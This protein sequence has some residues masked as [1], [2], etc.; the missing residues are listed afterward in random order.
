[1]SNQKNP[2][3]LI[4]E[5]SPYL[6]QHAY[7]PVAWYPWGNEAFEKAKK[8]EKPIFLSIGYST[9]HWCHVMENESFEDEEVANL[10]N[11]GFISIKVDKEERPDIDTVYMNVCQAYNGHGG[12][13]LTI[14]MTPE[15][16]PFFAGTYLPKLSRSNL[17]GLMDLLTTVKKQWKEERLPL[18]AAGEKITALL[19]SKQTYQ[20]PDYMI[21]TDIL[22]EGYQ[23][24][25][26]T[27]DPN[28]GGFGQSPKFP[29]PHNLLFL[30]RYGYFE[31]NEDATKMVY[32]T[33]LQMYLGGIYDHIGGGFSRYSTDEKWL[34]PHFEKMLYDNA[35]L[36]FT[37]LEAYEISKI[38]L[39]KTV[40]IRTLDYITREMLDES[41]GFYCAQDADS[42]GVEGKFYVFQKD[43][44][45]SVLGI[46]DGTYFCDY[47]GVTD[48]GN[49]EGSNILNLLK[50]YDYDKENARIPLLSTK[51]YEYRKTRT[52]LHKDDKILTSWN[53]LMIVA[54][55]KAY[56]VL[57]DE[58]YLTTASNS[59]DFILNNMVGEDHTLYTSYRKTRGSH[60][61]T[62]DDYS[63]FIWA[64]IEA[65]EVT[66]DVKY[67][68]LALTFNKKMTTEFFDDKEG[69]FYL[70]GFNSE[71]LILHPKEI[72][73]GAIPSGNSVATYCLGKLNRLTSDLSIQKTYEKQLGFLV[74][75]ISDYPSGYSFSLLSIINELY[76][77]K[78][79]ICVPA[80]TEEANNIKN[81]LHS[82]YLPNV[83]IIF[84]ERE[85]EAEL[86]KLIPNLENYHGTAGKT[87]FYLCENR[88][89]SA[90]FYSLEKLAE[91]LI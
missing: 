65:Y 68:E 73:D 52:T 44:I 64:L 14:L 78:E 69:G 70:Y 51:L 13:P 61:G 23:I 83:I 75:S 58:I 67:L 91:H 19:K 82:L 18:I 2:N 86:V 38:D 26:Q 34:V 89:C 79:L 50:N 3:K 33:L 48:T 41:G 28:Y 10:L 62:I 57:K 40:A 22:D 55:L 5:K 21:T 16:K 56:K 63:F 30:L 71:E 27:F 47:Y 6:L 35:L 39:F 12:W 17:F 81:L 60:L 80:T 7:N 36:S 31:H 85:N 29:S 43:E 84:K 42:E 53:S 66:F 25:A 20:D 54:Y 9:C 37:Y 1:M 74:S 72:Y 90:P 11:D 88:S 24:F 46:E 76:H 15:Q 4:H 32:K 87:T 77:A 8:E 45:L 59:I 49:F